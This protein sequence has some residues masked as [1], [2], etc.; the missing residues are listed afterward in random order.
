VGG[1]AGIGRRCKSIRRKEQS[2]RRDGCSD[3]AQRVSEIPVIDD[4]IKNVPSSSDVKGIER[5]G[6][7]FRD[8]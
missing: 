7:R 4:V 2:S 3:K 8:V 5:D 6:V 1:W